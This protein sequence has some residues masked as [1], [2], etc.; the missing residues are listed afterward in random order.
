[1]TAIPLD[2]VREL[3]SDGNLIQTGVRADE[4]RRARHGARTTFV[5]VLEV[6]VDAMPAA[7]PPGANVG[8]LRLIGAPSST[9]AAVRA[10]KRALAAAGD[11]PLTAFSMA[12]LARLAASASGGWGRVLA[13]LRDAG[14]EQIAE[15]PLDVLPAAAQA[16]EAVAAA[17]LTAPRL[18]VQH[19]QRDRD[20][21][22]ALFRRAAELQQAVGGIRAFAPLARVLDVAH[23][24]TGYDDV[25]TIALARLLVDNI[26]SIQ[27][28]WPLYGPKLAQVALTTGADDVDG[29]SPL[30]GE[31]G[32]RRSPLEEIRRNIAAAGLEAVQRD[33]RFRVRA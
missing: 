16:L 30:E 19:A 2:E 1:M 3:L 31:L 21:W 33:G 14:L 6:H 15:L 7:W 5:R 24:T 13:P 22:I 20:G 10:V 25:T 26:P 12:D 11:V 8:E 23:P 29:V 17:G 27:V 4:V 28:D 9:E 32:R 18:T